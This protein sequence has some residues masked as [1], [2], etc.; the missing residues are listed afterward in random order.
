MVMTCAVER[1]VGEIICTG[2][3]CMTGLSSNQLGQAVWETEKAG[4]IWAGI[5]T[6]HLS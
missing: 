4:K 2:T 1:N 5:R 6:D 3:S